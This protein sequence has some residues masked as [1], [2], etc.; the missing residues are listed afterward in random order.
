ME[1]AIKVRKPVDPSVDLLMNY[2]AVTETYLYRMTE[3]LV[4]SLVNKY[5]SVDTI[6]AWERD[7]I[8]THVDEANGEGGDEPM[9]EE[10]EDDDEDDDED[11][12]RSAPGLMLAEDDEDLPELEEEEEGEEEDPTAKASSDFW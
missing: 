4:S 10:E 2:P 9:N 11:C 12:V 1:Y 5:G 7:Y 3:D 8:K 6:P